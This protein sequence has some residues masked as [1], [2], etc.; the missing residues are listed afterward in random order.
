MKKISGICAL[1]ALLL[2]ALPARADIELKVGDNVM[3]TWSNFTAT[4]T[5]TENGTLTIEFEDNWGLT[6]TYNDKTIPMVQNGDACKKYVNMFSVGNVEAGKTVTIVENGGLMSAGC[7]VDFTP[8]GE[9]GGEEPGGEEPG[10][11]PDAIVLSIGENN[12][13]AYEYQAVDAKFTATEAGTLV[14]S[15]ADPHPP[16]SSSSS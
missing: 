4:F 2:A 9:P 16:P 13:S 3:P 15:C 7:Y 1:F 6:V 11:N 5:P 12:L 14:I 10:E 8:S